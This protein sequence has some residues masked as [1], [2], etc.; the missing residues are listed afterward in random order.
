MFERENAF[1]EANFDTLLTQY[2]DKEVAIVGDRI[3]G[4]FDTLGEAGDAV[5]KV[6]PRGTVCIKHVDEYAL[7][8]IY[9]FTLS[10]GLRLCA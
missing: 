2:P 5:D 10:R 3:I 7:E 1:F 9:I 8:P 6:Y 4:I